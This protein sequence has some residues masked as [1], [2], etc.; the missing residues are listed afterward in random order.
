RVA[1]LGPDLLEQLH[2]P[3]AP[4][5]KLEVLGDRKTPLPDPVGTLQATRELARMGSRFWRTPAMTRSPRAR[6]RRP[7]RRAA[8][9]PAAGPEAGRGSSAG[10]TSCCAGGR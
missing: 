1:R 6:S 2:N 5:V 3:G 9:P 8:C 4:R 10:T 7:G